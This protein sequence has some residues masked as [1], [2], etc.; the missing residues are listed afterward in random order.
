MATIHA[1][2]VMVGG[3]YV[4][5]DSHGCNSLVDLWFLGRVKERGEQEEDVAVGAKL[6]APF[7]T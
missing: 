6:I 4:V 7:R 1:I 5:K 2:R 3:K